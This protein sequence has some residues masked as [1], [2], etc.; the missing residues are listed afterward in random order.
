MGRVQ[1]RR[2]AKFYKLTAA[3][4]RQLHTETEEWGRIAAGVAAALET[5]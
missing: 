1:N 4:R 2:K 3:G 5:A